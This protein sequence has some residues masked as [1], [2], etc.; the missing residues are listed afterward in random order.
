MTDDAHGGHSDPSWFVPP[1]GGDFLAI[2]VL[3][4]VLGGL[5]GIVYLYA[6]FDR[7]AEHQAQGTPLAK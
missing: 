2:V 4:I 6:A 7:W 3:V 1:D 5:Y